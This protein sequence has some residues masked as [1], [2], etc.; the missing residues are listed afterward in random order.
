MTA[1]RTQESEGPR[2]IGQTLIRF[3]PNAKPSGRFFVGSS[4]AWNGTES[5]CRDEAGSW[6]PFPSRA[7]SARV[8]ERRLTMPFGTTLASGADVTGDGVDDVLVSGFEWFGGIPGRVLL[9]D[10]KTKRVIQ[11]FTPD[12]MDRQWGGTT[13]MIRVLPRPRA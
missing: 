8:A 9:I 2:L 12:E 5:Q 13:E 6:E 4:A 7:S 11:C 1:S 3:F 10:G